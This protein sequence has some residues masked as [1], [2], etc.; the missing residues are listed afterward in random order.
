MEIAKSGKVYFSDASNI[1]P[2]QVGSKWVSLIPSV[3]AIVAN[4]PK[5]RY[6]TKKKNKK[7]RKKEIIC[8]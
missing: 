5:G 3:V 1:G 7:E 6:N 8:I 2:I 4:D